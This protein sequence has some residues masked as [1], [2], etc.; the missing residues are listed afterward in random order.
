MKALKFLVML[1]GLGIF[2]F[3]TISC[4]KSSDDEELF[5]QSILSQDEI[6]SL[7]YMF[8]EE[9]LARDVYRYNF[10]H[11]GLI[12]FQN[13]ANSE[14]SHM[15]A[16]AFEMNRFGIV[17]SFDLT[18]GNFVN[19]VL[20][21]LYSDL[22]AKSDSSLYAALEV[23]A[24]IE[25]L[26]INDLIQIMEGSQNTYLNRMYSSLRC[27]S[28][29]HMRAFSS[30]LQALGAIYVPMFISD[31]LYQQILASPQSACGFQG[32]R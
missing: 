18:E 26:D 4:H 28:E 10:E 5:Q 20:S 21:K 29:N 13:I 11:Y 30:Q 1:F 16:V 19:P 23:G 14:Q 6:Q 22:I 3:S 9:K 17:Q 15:D 8:E 2:S 27:G 12:L 24:T 31:D 25:D 7:A 32:G